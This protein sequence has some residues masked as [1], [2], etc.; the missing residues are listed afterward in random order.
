[1]ASRWRSLVSRAL[2]DAVGPWPGPV[3]LNLPFRD[4]LVGQAGDLPPGRPDGR[5]WYQAV[6]GRRRARPGPARRAGGRPRPAAGGDRGRGR[7]RRSG[8]RARAGRRGRLAGARRPAVRL[9]AP[10]PVD[11]GRVRR[12]APPRRLRRRAH[13][14]RSSCDSG[15]R[16]PRRC[17]PSGWR[18]PAPSR[19]QVDRLGGVDRSR[20]A[21]PPPRRAPTRPRCAGELARP[22]VGRAHGTPWPARWRRAEA[23]APGGHRRRCWPATASR[24]SPA[25]PGRS[26]RPLPDGGDARRLVVDARPRRRVV[27]RA[28]RRA[29]RSLA[30]R[31]A[32]GIDGVV[33]T[34]VGRGARRR[35]RRPALLIGDVAF[36]HD[37]NGLARPAAGAA[38]TSRSSSSTTTAAASSRSCRRP[39]ALPAERFEQLFG[40]PHGVDLRRPGRRPRPAHGR[41][42]RTWATC[43]GCSATGP[44]SSGSAPTAPPTSPS[45]R[46]STTPS[47]PPSTDGRA[48]AHRDPRSADLRVLESVGA[49]E[50]D[51]RP[52]AGRADHLVGR[53]GS[54][55]HHAS[56][57]APGPAA[58]RRRVRVGDRRRACARPRPG[59][60]ARPGRDADPGRLGNRPADRLRHG[61]DARLAGRVRRRGRPR[62]PG[63]RPQ[64]PQAAGHRGVLG[65]LQVPLH[66]GGQQ[67]DPH[68][69]HG[70]LRSGNTGTAIGFHSIPTKHGQ[71][72]QSVSALGGA[73]VARLRP[74]IPR[75]RRV[76][77]L[78]GPG[79]A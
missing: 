67:P 16:R 37:T 55:I 2:A 20:A 64:V 75:Q 3:H 32:N 19:S 43:P 63:L 38:S 50:Y 28:P 48:P 23:L 6:S 31:G 29:S 22:P 61:H 46:P 36:L 25:W 13:A 78:L 79:G 12:P 44:A 74:P 56:C 7:R 21:P 65:V 60:A 51:S 27:R 17:W 53:S 58:R 35:R 11:G 4:P 72:I 45:T 14:R 26:W 24:P 9:P 15:A 40:T 39:T 57:V 77:L 33:S 52:R 42:S 1:M 66:G 30:N 5:P 41:R 69:V 68:G 71:A 62:L 54:A 34:A 18:P 73:G 47:S 10:A 8:R 59:P 76:P 70:P 49:S